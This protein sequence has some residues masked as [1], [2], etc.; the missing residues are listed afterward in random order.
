VAFNQ[1]QLDRIEEVVRLGNLI[2]AKR[3]ELNSLIDEWNKAF[4]EVKLAESI[5]ATAD[6]NLDTPAPA[7]SIDD[8]VVAHLDENTHRKFNAN[9]L[10]EELVIPPSSIGTQLSKLFRTGRIHRLGRGFYCS[11]FANP[12]QWREPEKEATEVA[13]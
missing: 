9:T 7:G 6:P 5:P 8:R 1:L 10:T 3:D 13:S 12:D 11:I 4:P 2:K